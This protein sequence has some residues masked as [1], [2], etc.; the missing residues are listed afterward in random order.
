MSQSQHPTLSE[1]QI[2]A[3]E[4]FG[5]HC[6]TD[7]VQQ[8]KLDSALPELLKNTPEIANIGDAVQYLMNICST[9]LNEVDLGDESVSDVMYREYMTTILDKCNDVNKLTLAVGPAKLSLCMVACQQG[10]KPLAELLIDRGADLTEKDP[11][12]FPMVYHAVLGNS[13][14]LVELLYSKGADIHFVDKNGE[15]LLHAAS[16]NG[17]KEIIT[18]LIE[19]GVDPTAVE[20][21][22]K[23]NCYST[24]AYFSDSP[25]VLALLDSHNVPHLSDNIFGLMPLSLAILSENH[26]NTEY[27]IGQ[28]NN[29]ELPLDPSDYE[30]ILVHAVSEPIKQS[31]LS[32]EEFKKAIPDILKQRYAKYAIKATGTMDPFV[33][34]ITSPE[35]V[36]ALCNAF[37]TTPMTLLRR[38][39]LSDDIRDHVKIAYVS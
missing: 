38:D 16:A 39:D 32:E 33:H 27:L 17:A 19:N 22:Y 24:T 23:M 13:L 12:G 26:G 6:L 34:S 31:K 25:D 2:S 30:G 37:D 8:S 35:Q 3:L 36:K 28:N 11:L 15:N 9:V 1:S 20:N 21:R 7:P 29:A 10:I 5:K 4:A 14:S 18:F